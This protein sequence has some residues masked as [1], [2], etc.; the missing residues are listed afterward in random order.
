[1]ILYGREEKEGIR[2]DV[3][4]AKCSRT[5]LVFLDKKILDERSGE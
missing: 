4:Y 1:M 2:S 5:K 3:F